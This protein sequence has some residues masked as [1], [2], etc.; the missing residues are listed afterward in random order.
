MPSKTWIFQANPARFN[1]SAFLAARPLHTEWLV[2]RYR[3][4]IAPGDKVFLWRSAGD[5][6]EPAGVIAEATVLTHVRDALSDGPSGFWSEASDS[7]A[8]KPRARISLDRVAN[9]REVIKRDWWKE[10]PVLREHLIIKMPN[11]TTFRI[12]G[13]M[14]AR[15]ERLWERTGSDFSYEDSLAGLYAFMQTR[16]APV[17]RSPGSAVANASLLIGRPVAG[18]YNK[19]MNFRSFDPEDT[20]TG[21]AGASEQDRAVWAQFY[22]DSGLRTS[23][24]EAEFERVWKLSGQ[25]I[26]ASSARQEFDLQVERLS[27]EFS[28]AELWA[29]Y[30]VRPTKHGGRPLARQGASRVYLRDPLVGAI[31]RK[32][33][34]FSCEAPGCGN[35]SFV[36]GDGVRYVEVHHIHTLAE[37][38]PDIAENVACLCPI[39]HREAHHG[40]DAAKLLADLKLLRSGEVSG[41]LLS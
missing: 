23:E 36:N 29:R 33:A 6:S 18:V 39:H 12:E 16:G 40:A 11:H 10:D 25:P 21:L 19:V 28:L 24:L 17:S 9:K 35:S 5:Q 13:D 34:S 38:G 27:Q 41:G 31:A 15:L 32:R 30:R 1:I 8:L 4:E 37:G 7:I 20:R 26:D 22:G 2:S 14:L 3:D